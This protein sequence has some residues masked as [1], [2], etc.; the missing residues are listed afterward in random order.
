[1]QQPEALMHGKKSCGK[2]TPLVLQ[3][4]ALQA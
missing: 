4:G 3:K 1:M 2:A